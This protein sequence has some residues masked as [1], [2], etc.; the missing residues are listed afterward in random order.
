M[1]ASADWGVANGKPW[2][3]V[4]KGAL[5]EPWRDASGQVV[6]DGVPVGVSLQ[7]VRRPSKT[8]ITRQSATATAA[9]HEEISDLALN[10][11]TFSW[12]TEQTCS[13]L[14]INQRL[15]TQIWR[16]SWSGPRGYTTWTTSGTTTSSYLRQGWTSNC[17]NGGGSYDYYGV[18]QGYATAIG[19][20]PKVRSANT[21]NHFNCG[22]NS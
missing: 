11:L 18:M 13:G 10:G 8:K 7:S 4:T 2:F 9:C 5:V 14:F 15:Q 3:H 19:W 16:S 12:T 17:N 6:S 20:G 1:V 21:L 22:P